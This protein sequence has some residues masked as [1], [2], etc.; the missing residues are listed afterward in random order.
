MRWGMGLG[1]GLRGGRAAPY[2]D[3]AL[4]LDFKNGA[5]R[6]AGLLTG[7]VTQLP[8]YSYTRS[9]P[10]S[11]LNANGTPVPFAANVPGI[12]P[13]VGHWSRAALTNIF[14]NSA[15]GATQSI[16]V[17][18][19]AYTLSFFG[20]GTITF[21]GTSTAGPLVGTGAS[22]RVSLTFTPTAGSLTLTI[23][24]SCTNVVLVAGTQA[25]PIITTAGAAVSIGA[26][27]LRVA[28]ALA[29]EDQALV[30]KFYLDDVTA[31]RSGYFMEFGDTTSQNRIV[32][33]GNNA[34]SVNFFTNSAGVTLRNTAIAGPPT[35]Q[36]GEFAVALRRRSGKWTAYHRKPDGT[37][38][39]EA[40]GAAMAF[41]V[42]TTTLIAGANFASNSQANSQV[43]FI[44]VRR[45]TFSDAELS[46][47]L[48]AA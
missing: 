9:G 24:G 48:A 19:Q 28:C 46:A 3:H 29:D 11:E 47:L 32:V 41:P 15:V 7:D 26:D 1:L 42:G 27:V 8:G 18:A 38:Q 20:T 25:G 12:M 33:F 23:S 6:S 10:K 39:T 40:E 45:G 35:L 36:V 22:A 13:G 37:V 34:G 4:A 31:P 44:G 21:S 43:R 17:A 5:Y 2:A 14:L 16:T 30:G